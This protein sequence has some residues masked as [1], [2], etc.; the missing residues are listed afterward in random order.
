MRKLLFVFFILLTVGIGLYV[1]DVNDF[2]TDDIIEEKDVPKL[3]TKQMKKDKKELL[4]GDLYN[5]VGNSEE[6]LEEEL[7][8]PIRKDKTPYGYVWWVYTDEAETYILYGVENGQVV[9]IFATGDELS[10]EPLRIGASYDD[11]VQHFP[12]EERVTY[13]DGVSFYT[14]ILNETD[15]ET[16]PLIKL[17]DDLFVLCYF[18]TF[19]ETLS[20]IRIIDGETLTE[21]RFFE[22]EYRGSLP[23]EVDV[24]DEE[25]QDI[26]EAMEEQIFELTNIYRHRF[27]VSPLKQDEAVAEVAYL[28][29]EDMHENQ[30]FSHTTEDGKGLKERLEA[31]D[32]Y[33]LSA[34]ENIAAQHTDALAAMEGWLN[35]EGHRE[36]LLYEDYN[37]LGV[38]VYRLYYTQNFLLKP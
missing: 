17:S 16:N 27:D 30:Y 23:D 6:E 22:M 19:D 26:E 7:G 15:L 11:I 5:M 2:F 38:G 18:D 1:V 20:S 35:S 21:Q 33:Y 9:T 34:G 12:L 25:W 4:H 29:S 37:Y 36:A 3:M 8:A 10:S 24:S 31:K 28:H 13:Q 32:I 14:F